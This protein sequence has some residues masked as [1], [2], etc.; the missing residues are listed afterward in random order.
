MDET[1]SEL[2][3]CIEGLSVEY[4]SL[5][6]VMKLERE[7]LIHAD[8]EQLSESNRLK[9]SMIWKIRDL[10][11]QRQNLS[12]RMGKSLAMPHPEPRLLE[13]A[14]Q[15]VKIHR[16]REAEVLRALHR[17]LEQLIQKVAMQN[18]ENEIYAENGLR[19]VRGA[20]DDV[21]TYFAKART[22]QRKGQISE[23]QEKSGNFVS[24]EA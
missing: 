6:Q 23:S 8:V 21:R 24:R 11:I 7:F 3:K 20:M 14:Q 1:L 15:L 16:P 2:Q 10:D 12:Q 22:Y 5:S 19:M 4:D 18:K 17:E 13:L 9:E